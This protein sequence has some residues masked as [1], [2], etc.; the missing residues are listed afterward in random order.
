MELEHGRGIDYYLDLLKKKFLTIL[1]LVLLIAAAGVTIVMALPKVYR[2]EVAILVEP[3]RIPADLSEN[4]AP[5]IVPVEPL[6]LIEQQIMTRDNLLRIVDQYGLF[7]DQALKWSRT[8]IADQMRKQIKIQR[9]SEGPMARPENSPS[10]ALSVEFEYG[11][12]EIA[13]RVLNEI[14]GSILV[15]DIKDRTSRASDTARILE[16]EVE[17]L[18]AQLTA[19]ETSISEFTQKHISSLPSRLEFNLNQIESRRNELNENDTAIRA[20]DSEKQLLDVE[21]RLKVSMGG[22]ATNDP[23]SSTSRLEALRSQLTEKSSLYSDTHPEVRSLRQQIA[24]AESE[25]NEKLSSLQFSGR[26][27]PSTL[28]PDLRLIAERINAL[29]SRHEFLLQRRDAIMSNIAELRRNVAQA[30]EVEA[31]LR[32]LQR[33]RDVLQKALDDLSSPLA[34]SQLRER[35]ERDER[36]ERLRLV[37]PAVVPTS[38]VKPNRLKLLALVIGLSF[39]I[40]LGSV[41]GIDAIDKTI[42]SPGDLMLSAAGIPIAEIPYLYTS[43]ER[44]RKR[45]KLILS[46]SSFCIVMLAGLVYSHVY[47][48][49]LDT[50][51]Q[52]FGS[53]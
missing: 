16:H 46:L 51:L 32:V 41:L 12:P 40:G 21:L 18:K 27:D 53:L 6:Q 47:F 50:V 28:P 15:E 20:L 2:A 52:K 39:G 23:Q 38:P 1:M 4:A 43:G 19:V 22:A 8:K 5:A 42:R 25:I 34:A 17:G 9:I 14:A 37:E 35:L 45:K 48:M 29:S 7:P 36:A 30:P 13:T 11:D 49:P 31:D 24:L 3:Q 44:S 26:I 33:Q 10:Y